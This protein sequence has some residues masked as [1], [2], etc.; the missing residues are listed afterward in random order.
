MDNITLTYPVIVLYGES[1]YSAPKGAEFFTD[2]HGVQWVKF[3][4][5]NGYHIGKEHML[6]TDRV[7]IIR[8]KDRERRAATHE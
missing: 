4:P 6:R 8:D 7:M 2:E 1:Q 3:F 5:T